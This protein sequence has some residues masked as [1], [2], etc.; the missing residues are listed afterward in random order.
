LENNELDYLIERNSSLKL[1]GKF[2]PVSDGVKE[3]MYGA[4]FGKSSK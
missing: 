1:N 4:E 3:R 2:V